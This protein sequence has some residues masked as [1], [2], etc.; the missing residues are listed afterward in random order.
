MADPDWIGAPV[1]DSYWSVDGRSVYYTQKRTGSQLTDLHEV[2]LS[3]GKDQI[4]KLEEMAKSDGPPQFDAS[5]KRAAFV[6]HGDVFVRDGAAV[7]Q[8]SRGLAP[9]EQLQF[10]GDGKLLSFRVMNDWYVHDLAS[11]LTAR[12]AVLMTEKDPNGEQD[13]DDLRDVQLRT[14]STLKRMHDEKQ[15]AHEEDLKASRLDATR[16]AAPFYLGEVEIQGTSLSPDARWLLVVTTP[17]S[18]AK[19][20]EGQLTRYVTESGY[21]E[22]EK[23]RTRVG[24]NT[25]APQSVWLLDIGSHLVHQLKTDEL[26]GIHEDPLK[27]V[28]QENAVHHPWVKAQSPDAGKARGVWVLSDDPEIHNP[29]V[30]WSRDA[31][32]LA[33]AVYSIDNKDRWIASVDFTHFTLNVEDRLSDEAWVNYDIFNDYGWLNDNRTLWFQS[34]KSGYGHLYLKKP[35]E[36]ATALTHGDFEVSQPVLSPDGHMFYVLANAKAP[37]SYDVYRLSVGGGN[38]ERVTNL[39]GVAHFELEERGRQLLVQYS[40]SYIPTQLAVVP[41]DGKGKARELTDTRS[42]QYKAISWIKP[43]IVQISSTHVNR[44]IFGKL[45]RDPAAAGGTTHPAVLFV[46]G[47]GYLQD[48]HLSYPYYFREQMFNNMLAHKGY[49]V[50]DIDYRASMGYGRDWRTAIYRQMGHPELE[51]L[52]DAKQWLVANAKADPARFGMY[53]GSYG[54]FMTLMALFRAPGEF[55]AGAALRPV[56]DW[57][58]YNEQY[59][60]A[61]LNDPKIDPIAYEQSSPIEFASAFKDHLL[62]CHGV[63]DDNVLFEDSMRL[64]ERLIELH[65][66]NFSMSP[67]PL[68]R[69]GFVNADSWL[70]EYKRIYRL[71]EAELDHP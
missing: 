20:R 19:G 27:A 69:H 59:T 40:N 51:D 42:D 66:D 70:D 24:R 13:P 60:A 36:A 10:S 8:V 6:R 46:H 49:V 5:G 33:F 15:A 63:I 28:R 45:Y 54:G 68:D 62:I 61:I 47:A 37:Y 4:V 17:K 26:P 53:G 67:Y 57:W 43:E 56:T 50:L 64:Y 32:S 30:A 25:P 9:A 18:A 48:V 2:S 71:F 38:L 31:K 12:A 16:S 23:E 35:G 41:A 22:F 29:S 14:F 44:P 58:Q 21:E 65:K 3:D 11:G 7:R 39:E 34:E 55:K 52:L 1:R